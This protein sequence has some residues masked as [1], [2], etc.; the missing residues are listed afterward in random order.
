MSSIA[1]A[2]SI[3]LVVSLP[4]SAR[5]GEGTGTAEFWGHFSSAGKQIGGT[6]GIVSSVR[7]EKGVFEIE[8]YRQIDKCGWFGSIHGRSA[9]SVGVELGK[10]TP[11]SDPRVLEVRTF[12]AK[13]ALAKRDFSL[14]VKCQD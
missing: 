2:A 7:K 14:L 9:G 1:L 11:P 10:S 8:F 6:S 12:D 5:P 3:A 4:A 13:G